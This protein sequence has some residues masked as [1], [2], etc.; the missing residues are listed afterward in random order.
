LVSGFV[1]ILFGLVLVLVLHRLDDPVAASDAAMVAEAPVL[2][3]ID[4]PGRRRA[5][6]RGSVTTPRRLRTDDDLEPFRALRTN[7]RHAADGPG[8]TILLT[9]PDGGEGTST[10]TANLAIALCESGLRVVA[11]SVDLRR[12]ALG[13]YFGIDEDAP[14]LCEVLT[15]AAPITSVAHRVPT[16]RGVLYVVTSGALPSNPGELL[17]SDELARMLT[18]LKEAG[19]D[20]LLLDAPGVRVSADA[21]IVSRVADGVVV[22]CA[23]EQT[24]RAHLREAVEQLRALDA[25]VWGVVVNG[26][27]AGRTPAPQT[28]PSARSTA[29]NVL[30]KMRASRPSDQLSM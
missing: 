11:V 13:A 5:F 24:R 10:V 18:W 2:G 15:G 6:R 19:G 4:R 22:V 1:G 16:E 27:S 3:T 14:G 25:E 7:L 20:Y 29:G 26:V 30:S 28:A 23:E 8:C 12:P 21:S 9:G 17:E